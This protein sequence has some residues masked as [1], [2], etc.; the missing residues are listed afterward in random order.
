MY[1]QVCF[2][3]LKSTL[4][5][6]CQATEA[7]EDLMKTK[8][9]LLNVR[10][11]DSIQ[12]ASS[13]SSSD[14]ESDHE[15]SEENSTHSAELQDIGNHHEEV[16]RVTEAEKNKE[17]QEKLKVGAASEHPK[18]C[19]IYKHQQPVIIHL[20][21]CC[22]AHISSIWDIYMRITQN[23]VDLLTKWVI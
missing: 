1:H 3:P 8:E 21:P 14:S 10:R 20:N 12:P 6:P 15:D 13:S 22:Q 2:L 23:I 18:P 7:E 9:E 11:V 19:K 5:S 16:E 17:L 4:L